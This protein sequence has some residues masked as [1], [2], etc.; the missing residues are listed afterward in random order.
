MAII[1]AANPSRSFPILLLPFVEHGRGENTIPESLDRSL[2]C[3]SGPVA[4]T[5][6]HG[7]IFRIH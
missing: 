7:G 2:M 3:F 1:G 5:K 6:E 4:G